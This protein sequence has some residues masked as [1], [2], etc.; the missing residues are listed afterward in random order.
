MS[1]ATVRPA[2]VF[3]DSHYAA[4]PARKMRR[5]LELGPKYYLWDLPR[6]FAHR[7]SLRLPL[8]DWAVLVNPLREF[9]PHATD[10]E[11][12]PPGYEKGLR[13]LAE[14]G[15]RLTIPR[16]RLE[17]LLT[18]WWG[19]RDTPGDNIECGSYR[20]ATALLLAWLGRHNE[21]GRRT[22]ML[23]TFA[24]M[25]PPSVFDAARLAGEFRPPADQAEA[26]RRQAEALGVAEQVEVHAGLFADTFARLAPRRPRFAFV[27]IDANIYAGTLDACAFTLP[28]VAPGG[29]IVFDDYNGVCD[30]GARLAIDQALL[31]TGLRPWPLTVSSAW[32]RVPAGNRP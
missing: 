1:S 21:L 18:V 24:G 15:V 4:S 7:R 30:L 11:D 6:Y 27:H 3:D 26:I 16:G 22:L 9:Q 17:A 5:A 29:A 13:R 28:R 23:D 25:P 2:P 8:W 12:L 14:A 10:P 20:G 31:G 32:V 19:T